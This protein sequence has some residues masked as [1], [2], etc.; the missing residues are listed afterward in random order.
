MHHVKKLQGNNLIKKLTGTKNLTLSIVYYI[1]IGIRKIYIVIYKNYIPTCLINRVMWIYRNDV[2]YEMGVL[3]GG[4]MI[5]K[6]LID[7][8]I[9]IKK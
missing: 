4:N 3:E 8:T 7:S 5:D 9:S 1:N 6:K 2:D